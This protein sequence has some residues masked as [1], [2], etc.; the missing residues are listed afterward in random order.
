MVQDC[1]A[2]FTL[3]KQQEP[4]FLNVPYFLYS[5]FM[6]GAI[7]LMIHFADLE[8]VQGA[9][10]VAPM[11]KLYD[12]V[13]PRWPIPQILTFLAKFFPSLAIVPTVDLMY[14]SVKVGKTLIASCLSKKKDMGIEQCRGQGERVSIRSSGLHSFLSG[15]ETLKLDETTSKRTAGAKLTI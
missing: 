7:C 13:K 4:Q 15:K 2:F 9:I 8:A 14:K 12:K 10:L 11:C 5:E 3:V 1:L 6:G